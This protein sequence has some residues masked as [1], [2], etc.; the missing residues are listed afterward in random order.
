MLLERNFSSKYVEL[1]S[2]H[3]SAVRIHHSFETDSIAPISSK[4][5][6]YIAHRLISL[7]FVQLSGVSLIEA[8]TMA[9]YAPKAPEQHK[10][11]FNRFS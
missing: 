9:T 3:C 10:H 4:A 1:Y 5:I 11:L 2:N 8:N 7:T 6:T